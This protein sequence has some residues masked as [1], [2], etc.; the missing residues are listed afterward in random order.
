MKDI[1]RSLFPNSNIKDDEIDNIFD[2]QIEPD[3]IDASGR[4]VKKTEEEIRRE[5]NPFY[6]NSLKAIDVEIDNCIISRTSPIPMH[7]SQ[8]EKSKIQA[9][10]EFAKMDCY[11]SKIESYIKANLQ[12][13]VN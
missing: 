5:L 9:S 4:K 2:N 8:I 6:D 1:M 11:S 3:K 12:F 7:L 10:N 13:L